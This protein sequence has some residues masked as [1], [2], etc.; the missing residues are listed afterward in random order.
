MAYRSVACVIV[1]IFSTGPL[2]ALQ[3]PFLVS[4]SVFLYFSFDDHYRAAE[5]IVGMHGE[6]LDG[7]V[8]K[9]RSMIGSK[10]AEFQNIH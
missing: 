10:N 2:N 1:F 7:N 4:I 5:A 3:F 8:L 9:V 6:N